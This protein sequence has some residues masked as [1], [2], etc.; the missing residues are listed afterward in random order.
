MHYKTT[1]NIQ[2]L[3]DNKQMSCDPNKPHK[4]R[5][6]SAARAAC[7]PSCC[8]ACWGTEEILTLGRPR[9]SHPEDR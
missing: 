9:L 3:R 6:Q 2:K 8:S 5:S 1:E 4:R 7:F